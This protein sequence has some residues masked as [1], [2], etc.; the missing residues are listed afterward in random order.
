M[1]SSGS[2]RPSATAAPSTEGQ[3]DGHQHRVLLEEE[4]FDMTEAMLDEPIIGVEPADA[5]AAKG[6]IQPKPLPSPKPMTAAQKAIHDLRHLPHDPACP[7]CAS[8]RGLILPHQVSNEYLRVIPLLV[9]D[10]CFVRFHGDKVLQTVLVLRLIPYRLRFCQL[11]SFQRT[12]SP[13]CQ[14]PGKVCARR[15]ADT[16]R[17]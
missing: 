16:L 3:G 7:V 11:C 5:A 17:L 9:A 1:L 12:T 13:G 8:S 14:A 4:E 15:R 2:V 6:A 10:Y